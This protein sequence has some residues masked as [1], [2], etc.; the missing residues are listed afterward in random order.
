MNWHPHV[1]VAAIIRQQDHYLLVE[2]RIDG[3]TVFNQPAGHWQANETLLDAVKREVLEETTHQ[4]T[5]RGLVGIY[6][7]LLPASDRTYL[8]FCFTGVTGGPQPQYELDTDIIATHWLTKSEI[9]EKGDALRSPLVLQCIHD[10]T[11]R[12]DLPLHVIHQI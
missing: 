12:P 7:W 2:E 11:N 5:P 9:E 8:R 6:Q 1:T 3:K 4:F 10:A